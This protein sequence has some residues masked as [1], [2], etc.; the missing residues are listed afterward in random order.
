MQVVEFIVGVLIFV[1]GLIISIGLHEVGH[2]VPAKAFGVKVRQYMIGFGPTLFSR[3]RGGTEYGFKAILL[4]GY[5]AMEGMVPTPEELVADK[6]RNDDAS[7][8]R[9]ARAGASTSPGGLA[10]ALLT[11]PEQAE[12]DAEA[13]VAVDKT[14][15]ATG[16]PFYALAAPK[17]IVIMLGGPFVN[18][19]LAVIFFVIA[20]SGIGAPTIGVSEVSKCVPQSLTTSCVAGAPASPAAAAGLQSGDALVSIDGKPI[21]DFGVVSATVQKSAGKTVEVVVKRDGH[22]KTLEVTPATIKSSDAAD[23]KSIGFLGVTEGTV[24]VRQPVLTA[25]GNGLGSIGT[26]F[27]SFAHLPSEVI[28]TVT[29]TLDSKPRSESSPVSVVGVGRIAG[30]VT[31]SDNVSPMIKIELL[32]GLLG[33]LNIALLVL[34]ILPLMPFDGGHVVVALWQIV[35]DAFNRLRGKPAGGPIDSSR[36]LPL[37]LTVVGLLVGLSVI[38][39]VADLVNPVF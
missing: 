39:T 22:E 32:I 19:I 1:V 28:Q 30:T 10:N 16:M 26:S 4:G 15:E 7:S 13:E 20:F 38:L 3:V 33:S 2:L 12:R 34:N 36:Q 6:Q 24:L 11:S 8:R 21:T 17:R 5:I 27:A 18:L 35:R 23:A 14:P 31:A 37:T 29:S 25:V 9:L